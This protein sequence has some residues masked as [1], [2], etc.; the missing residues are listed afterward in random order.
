MDRYSILE[1][2]KPFGEL[3]HTLSTNKGPIAETKKGIG[4]QRQ[5]QRERKEKARKRRTG[6]EKARKRR[7]GRE[8]AGKKEEDRER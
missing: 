3:I 8:K 6:R 2:W 1:P 7:T 4:E 5:G